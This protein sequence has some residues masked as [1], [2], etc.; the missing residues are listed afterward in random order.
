MRRYIALPI[1]GLLMAAVPAMA[2]QDGQ[3]PGNEDLTGTADDLDWGV[4]VDFTQP[5]PEA[6]CDGDNSDAAPYFDENGDFVDPRRNCR[7]ESSTANDQ[8]PPAPEPPRSA[9]TSE[10]SSNCESDATGSSC[11]TSVIFSTGTGS[12]ESRRALEEFLNRGN[13]DDDD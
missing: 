4:T 9:W 6:E 5:L 13:D 10:T 11:S 12:S 1:A 7:A 2:Q 3:G 8:P